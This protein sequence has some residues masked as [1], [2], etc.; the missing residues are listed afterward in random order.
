[1]FINFSNHKSSTWSDEQL[2]AAS[3]YGGIWDLPFPSVP[4][5]MDSAGVAE[6]ARKY[7][8]EILE[9]KPEAV[10]CQGEM[11]LVFDVVQG[12]L[13]EGITVVAACSE[14][15]VE[16]KQLPDGTTQ[17]TAVFKFKQ[18]RRYGM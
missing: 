10:M 18:F 16:E 15:V 8:N 5:N 2:D 4:A 6:L 1:M 17:K 9:V 12:L 11:T 14:R 7:I 13:D 3:E